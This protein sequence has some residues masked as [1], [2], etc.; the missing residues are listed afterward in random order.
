MKTNFFYTL[1]VFIILTGCSKNVPL[2]G[3]VTFSDNGEPLTAGVV[4][5]VS[6]A[7]QARGNIQS[8]GTYTLGFEEVNN[9]LPNGTYN[10]Y[11]DDANRYEGGKLDEQGIPKS[12]QKVIPLINKKF[13][14]SE[15]SGLS[16]DVN[17]SLK[18]YDIKVDRP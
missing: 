13:T 17:N 2:S 1:F 5:F 14:K 8:N 3:N 9:G 7:H 16:V 15:T 4:F 10:V 18:K 6:G 12:E 11:I